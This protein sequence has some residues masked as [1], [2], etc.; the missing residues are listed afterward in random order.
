MHMVSCIRV[1]YQG[2]LGLSKLLSP[3]NVP[4]MSLSYSS[5]LDNPGA[6]LS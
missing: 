2:S 1:E 4:H 5:P 6:L 3:I